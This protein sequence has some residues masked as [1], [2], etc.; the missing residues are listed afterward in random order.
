MSPARGVTRTGP[1]EPASHRERGRQA[2]RKADGTSSSPQARSHGI[3]AELLAGDPVEVAPQLLGM[4]L[5]AGGTAGRI[6]EVEAYRGADDAAS[7]AFRGP[8]QRNRTMFG[9]PGL[10]YVYLSYGMH[11]CCN[12]V[13]RQ[14]GQ[15]GAVLIRALAPL[16]GLETMRGRR[17]RARRDTDLCSGP[18]KLCQALGLDR[19]ADGLDLLDPSSP[20]RL[21]EDRLEAPPAVASGPRI[22]LAHALATAGEPW[23]FFVIGDPNVSRGP[24]AALS[25]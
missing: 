16:S 5:D 18:G 1:G 7:H 8:T 23:R 25:C 13:C 15:A 17:L 14:E 3:L 11:Y 20:V 19:G 24:R 9:P 4:R 2:P 12:V 22:G 10:L 21:V 6:V